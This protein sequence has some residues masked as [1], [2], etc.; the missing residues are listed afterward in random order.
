[1]C[2]AVGWLYDLT[3]VCVWLY[4]GSMILHMCVCVAVGWH[5]W[6]YDLKH[7]CVTL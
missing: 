4:V 3:H 1:M 7:V 5:V 2:V 6:L